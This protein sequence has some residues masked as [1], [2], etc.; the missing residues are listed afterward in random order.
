MIWLFVLLLVILAIGGGIAVSKF[1]F[2]VLLIA[3]VLALL[4]FF[5]GRASA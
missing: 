3:L 5:G 4:G 2:A 1:L